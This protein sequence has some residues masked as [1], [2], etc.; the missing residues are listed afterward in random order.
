MQA[1]CARRVLKTGGG[2]GGGGGWRNKKIKFRR[3]NE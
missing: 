1:K 2:G 3:V